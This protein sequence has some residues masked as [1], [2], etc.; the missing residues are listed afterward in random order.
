MSNLVFLRRSYA[1]RYAAATAFRKAR[2]LPIG[3][4]R[5]VQRVLARGLRDLA[6]SEAW[7]EGQRSHRPQFLS[8]PAS[9]VW[10]PRQSDRCD[11]RA[12]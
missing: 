2:E 3:S 6:R 12:T 5:N 1:Y 8:A 7:L 4:E 10:K 11:G 9:P